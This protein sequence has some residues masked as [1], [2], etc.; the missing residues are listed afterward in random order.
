[1]PE[2]YVLA[3]TVKVTPPTEEEW[4][5]EKTSWIESMNRGSEQQAVQAFLTDLRN[6]A[7]VR[8]INPAVLE[9]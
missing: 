4:E 3:K 1:M 5:A 7:D 8:I 9:N 2:G 6:K